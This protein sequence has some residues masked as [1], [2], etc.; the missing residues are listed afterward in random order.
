[1]IASTVGV[2]TFGLPYAFA[3]SGFAIGMIQ[4]LI[5]AVLLIFLQ[6]MFSE[7]VMQTQ[8]R[9][10]L[11]GYIEIY[12]GRRFGRIAFVTIALSMW[13]AMLVHM[14]VAGN[15]LSM[16]L[17]PMLGGSQ[18][19]YGLIVIAVVGTLICRGIGIASRIEHVLM[20]ALAFL[21]IFIVLASV[22]SINPANLLTF[23][24]ENVMVPYGVI[25]FAMASLMIVPEIRDILGFRLERQLSQ[26]IMTSMLIVVVVYVGFVTVVLGV[27]G[28]QT[29]PSAFDGLMNVLGTVGSRVALTLGLFTVMSIFMMVGIQLKD[30]F[31]IDVRIPERWACLLVL[32]VPTLLYLAG[33][34]NVIQLIGFIGSVFGG[35]L[36]VLVVAT[37]LRMRRSSIC[38]KH[39]CIL[40]PTSLAFAII[41]L[42]VAGLSIKVLSLFL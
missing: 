40:F 23:R 26:V 39:K 29:T 1:M 42:F 22:S 13:G 18:Q 37:Y 41:A 34:S 17:S 28:D 19:L 30:T 16:L 32:F 7:V 2:G 4:L 5:M 11:I 31:T 8:G 35:V 14:L 12:L 21:F 3:Q 10:R 27:S 36:G 33:F 20:V 24:P 9:H 15:F 25:L 38:R 6:L